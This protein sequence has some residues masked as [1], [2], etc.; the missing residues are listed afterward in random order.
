MPVL[1]ARSIWARLVESPY[2]FLTPWLFGVLA[3]MA[4]PVLWSFVVSFTDYSFSPRTRFVGLSN[5][6]T[7]LFNDPRFV[8]SLRVTA[9]YIFLGVPLQVAFSLAVA[10]ALNKRF[11]GADLY[12]AALFVPSL[13]GGSVAVA[14]LWTQVFGNPGILNSALAT[15]GI[16][17]PNWLNDPRFAIYTLVALRV[18][19]F[20]SSMVIFLAALR[21]IPK[22]VLEAAQI[23]GAS[24]WVTFKSVVLPLLAPVVV[25]NLIMQMISASQTFTQAYI[26]SGGTGAPANSL[27]FYTLYLYQRGLTNFQ[28]GYASAMAW[29][30]L[31]VMGIA[32]FLII[33]FGRRWTDNV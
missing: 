1:S 29:F 16:R 31:L 11:M 10:V 4:L 30:L 15:F 5:Y 6:Q 27:L 23:D 13:L 26:I 24:P 9:I 8:Q 3:L 22:D 18:W 25:F 14:L 17:A 33:R 12:R 21:Q 2:F 32:T 20:G 7:M 19:E 28:M